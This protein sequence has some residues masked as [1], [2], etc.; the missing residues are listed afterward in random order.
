[1]ERPID[2][3]WASQEMSGLRLPDKRFSDNIIAITESISN[4]IG[5]S[6]S[7]ACGERLRKSAWRLFSKQ[8]LSLLSSHQ[9]QTLQRCADQS[10]ILIV[11]DTTDVVYIQKQKQGL[12][13]LGGPGTKGLNIHTALALSTDGAALGI[14]YQ[15]IWA[16]AAGR[17]KAKRVNFPIEEKETIK[18]IQTLA[19][20]N[21]CWADKQQ[22]V[23]VIA[24]RE[25]DFFEHY[26]QPRPAHVHLLVRV[27]K[28][29]RNI[30]YNGVSLSIAEL[31]M[32]LRPIG[33]S[34]VKVWRRPNQAERL[35]TVSYS[36]AS[37]TIPPT[38]KQTLPAQQMNLIWVKEQQGIEWILLTSLPVHTLEGAITIASYYA[39]R[40]V[41]ERFHFILK[42]GLEIESLQMDTFTRLQNALQLYALVAWHLLWLYRLGKY[43]PEQAAELYFDAESIEVLETISHKPIKKVKDFLIQLGK[44]GGFH[45]TTKQPLPGE[46]T[47]W[48]GVWQLIQ[49]RTGFL[50]AKLKYGTG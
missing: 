38:Y 22:K 16:P 23:V 11:E 7:S 15:K 6:F 25:A 31:L 12:G 28:K 8:D 26:A 36:L 44:L 1:M 46:K 41:V 32:E 5:K 21:H 14:I 13:S 19:T 17:G 3:S 39:Q 37:V 35:A 30:Y 10:T 42:S 49:I 48:L 40:W 18:W 20:V 2:G 24:D 27:Q 45:Q 4:N 43:A 34:Q 33:S 47:L 29:N 50:A 9:Q